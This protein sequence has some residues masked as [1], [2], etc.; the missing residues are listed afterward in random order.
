M[1]LA[2][3]SNLGTLAREAVEPLR[4]VDEDAALQEKLD[5]NGG[6]LSGEEQ[7]R[8]LGEW[9]VRMEAG[10]VTESGPVA[11]ALA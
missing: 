8:R 3:L 11:E 5:A 6:S 4:I 7:A 1:R 2:D 10:R 9:I